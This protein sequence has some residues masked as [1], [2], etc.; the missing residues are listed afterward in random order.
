MKKFQVNNE[1][2]GQRADIFLADKL[3]Y[4]RSSLEHLFDLNKVG[5]NNSNVK[6]GY[7][8]KS[9]DELK[10]D[11]AL[12]SS[13]PKN[14]EIP[15]LYE[16]DDVI[17]L[18][19]PAG[20]LTH[21]KGALNTEATVASF[22]KDK[23]T[24]KNLTGNRAGI[25]HRLDRHTSGVIITAKTEPALKWLQNQFSTRKVFKEYLAV[26]DGEP[27][28]KEAKIDAPIARNPKRPNTFKVSSVGK[29]AQTM[30]RVKKTF[31]KGGQ[32][33]SLVELWPYTGRTHQIRVHMS[34]LGNPIVGDQTYGNGIGHIL[35]HAKTLE[36]ILPSGEKKKFTSALPNVIK[37]YLS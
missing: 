24:D 8:L 28:E 29:S 10:V 13:Q 31:K 22:I 23:I 34:Y 12:L 18:N 20:I 16:D 19:K 11:D 9:G 1:S 2:A 14:I 33:Y 3:G 27:K 32:T 17:V 5:V 37:E 25:V 36:L 6:N 15:I 35:L 7:K 26:V 21:S 4:S 30:Y